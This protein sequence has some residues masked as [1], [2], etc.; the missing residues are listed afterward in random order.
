MVQFSDTDRHEYYSTLWYFSWI[1]GAVVFF[2]NTD[3]FFPPFT[4]K[5]KLLLLNYIFTSDKTCQYNGIVV[6]SQV[7]KRF[8]LNIISSYHYF[9]ERH[10][11]QNK[12]KCKAW[13]WTALT[14]KQISSSTALSQGNTLKRE[15]II[16][17]WQRKLQPLYNMFN[18]N[19]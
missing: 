9:T 18:R 5:G 10:I 13:L 6:C 15:L 1:E 16:W 11:L 2:L 12:N 8:L 17:Q 3:F 14:T 19:I 4:M 7:L